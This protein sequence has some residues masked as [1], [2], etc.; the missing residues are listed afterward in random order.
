V[1]LEHD[2]EHLGVDDRAG[3]EKLH[4][5]NLTTD[6]RGCTRIREIN[7]ITEGNEGKT[8]LRELASQARHQLDARGLLFAR[9]NCGS[10]MNTNY[11][12]RMGIWRRL[13][14]RPVLAMAL[15]KP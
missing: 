4:A 10:R 9:A 2:E 3:I 5:K 15:R 14:A 6:G 8:V 12:A 11:G 1:L 13:V 7:R